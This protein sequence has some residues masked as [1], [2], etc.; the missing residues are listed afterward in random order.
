MSTFLSSLL[1]LFVISPSVWSYEAPEDKEDVFAR[2]ACPAFLTFTNA[3]YLCGATVELPCLCKPQQVQSVVWFFRKHSGSPEETKGLTDHHGN[4]LLD[5]SQ[6]PHHGD[7]RS[8]FSIRLFSLLIFRAGPDDAGLYICGSAHRDFFY[9]YD[10]DIQEVHVISFTSRRLSSPQPLFQTFTR[11]RSWSEC[12]RCGLL[13][14]QVRA[15]LCYVHSQYLHVRYRRTNQT[16]VS[17]GSGAVPRAFG[18]LK[19]K[20]GAKLEVRGCEVTCPAQAPKGNCIQKSV[21]VIVSA[22]SPLEVPVL[23]LNHPADQ[24]LTL[25]CP[26][27]RSNMV[28][29]WDRGSEPLYRSEHKTGSRIWIDTGHHLVF[30]PARTQDSGNLQ[31]SKVIGQRLSVAGEVYFYLPVSASCLFH[32]YN[33]IWLHCRCHCQAAART[34]LSH[35]A[36]HDKIP[37]M[38]KLPPGSVCKHM[39]RLWWMALRNCSP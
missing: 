32:P 2:K 6:V 19:K 4:Q 10:L 21:C 11:F 20:G 35:N 26:G 33:T 16:V 22:S 24:I 27:A 23:Y 37:K 31:R 34:S 8:R 15:G 13:G 7:L 39:V 1:L 3:A 29:A 12:D 14:E 38:P 28:V 30:K 17:C 36:R 18:P 9:G 25:G 5:S